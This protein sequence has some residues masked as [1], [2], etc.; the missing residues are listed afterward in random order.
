MKD[1]DLIYKILNTFSFNFEENDS[2]FCF[3][4]LEQAIL[5]NDSKTKIETSQVMLLHIQFVYYQL[6]DHL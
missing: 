1:L 6:K 5:N 3:E 4:F 2:H